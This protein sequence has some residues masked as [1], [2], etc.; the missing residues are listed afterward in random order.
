MQK[1]SLGVDMSF[2]TFHV[3]LSVIEQ[4]QQVKVKAS[5]S[6]SNNTEG[7]KLLMIGLTDIISRKNCHYQL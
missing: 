1:Y 7:F 5:T 3:C 4:D 2:K 6:F